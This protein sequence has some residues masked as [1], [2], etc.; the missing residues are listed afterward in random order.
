MNSGFSGASVCQRHPGRVQR[1]QAA[2]T[3]YWEVLQVQHAGCISM[4]CPYTQ[5]GKQ[6]QFSHLFH[7]CSLWSSPTRLQE[8]ERL[9]GFPLRCSYPSWDLGCWGQQRL[10]QTS[11]TGQEPWQDGAV[12]SAA[13]VARVDSDMLPVCS[14]LCIPS[15]VL[16]GNGY[17]L[18]LYFLQ[19]ML[20]PFLSQNKPNQKSSE[21]NPVQT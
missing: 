13:L 18:A 11:A 3:Q 2:L 15:K 16:T 20:L 4:L 21:R 17:S 5:G 19:K 12:R 1:R 9:L 8:A 7:W 6:Q 14:L 10:L